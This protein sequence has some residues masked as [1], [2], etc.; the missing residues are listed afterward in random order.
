MTVLFLLSRKFALSKLSPPGV[1][2]RQQRDTATSHPQGSCKIDSLLL[3]ATGTG[4]RCGCVGKRAWSDF[5]TAPSCIRMER[6]NVE[7]LSQEIATFRW[8]TITST[9]FKFWTRALRKFSP[10]KPKAR[11]QYGKL[12]PITVTYCNLKIAKKVRLKSVVWCLTPTHTTTILLLFCLLF[13]MMFLGILAH[14][15]LLVTLKRNSNP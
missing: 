2:T 9:S 13:L 5:T 3:S 12:V 6:D 14:Q 4:I 15:K 10:F 1:L 8:R 11:T 7:F